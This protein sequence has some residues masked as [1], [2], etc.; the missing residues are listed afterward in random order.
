MRG[1]APQQPRREDSYEED[2]RTSTAYIS[3]EETGFRRNTQYS[4][5]ARQPNSQCQMD[6]S[7]PVR[8]RASVWFSNSPSTQKSRDSAWCWYWTSQRQAASPQPTVPPVR[9]SNNIS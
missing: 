1:P 7:S 5:S 3:E 2:N 8:S 6:A 4:P 9:R